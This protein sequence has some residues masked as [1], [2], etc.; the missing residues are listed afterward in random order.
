MVERPLSIQEVPGSIPSFSKE[1]TD[2]FAAH[3]NILS[4]LFFLFCWLSAYKTRVV[5]HCVTVTLLFP[6]ISCQKG[7]L[8]FTFYLRK[9]L[10]TERSRPKYQSREFSQPSH[11]PL[12]ILLFFTTLQH[13]SILPKR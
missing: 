4:F 9:P 1:N 5:C 8:S 7:P 3:G 11:R 2:V 12:P 6:A 13:T 10:R